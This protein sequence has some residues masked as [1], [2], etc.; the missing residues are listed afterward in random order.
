M[1]ANVK[2]IEETQDNLLCNEWQ[3][4]ADSVRLNVWTEDNDGNLVID[5]VAK[6]QE[7][8]KRAYFRWQNGFNNEC[9]NWYQAEY[10]VNM[11]LFE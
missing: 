8:A 5:E 11:A 7:I 1:Q 10:E 6:N 2:I 4:W 9:N 3:E